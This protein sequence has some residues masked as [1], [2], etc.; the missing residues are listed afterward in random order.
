MGSRILWSATIGFLAGVL[1]R[2]FVPLGPNYALFLAAITGVF[3]LVLYLYD[4]VHFHTGVV[5]AI[6]C[7]AFAGGIM[8]M[9]AAILP[10]DPITHMYVGERVTVTG[11][12]FAEPDARETNTRLS[13]RAHTLTTAAGSSTI[14]TGILAVL[15]P[16]TH[17]TYGDEIVVSGILR[18]PESF[19]TT[20]GRVFNYPAYLAVSGISY[21]LTSAHIDSIGENSGNAGYALVI[22]IKEVYLRGLHRALAEP[23]AGLA[24]GITVGDKRSIGEDLSADFQRAS[25]IHMLVL[26]GYNITV[27]INAAAY[28]FSRFPRIIQFGTSGSIVVFF[29]ALSGGASSAVRAGLMALIA[30]YARQHGRVFLPLRA[31]GTVAVGMAL[32]NPYIVAF[33]PGFQLSAL[34]TIGL[35]AFTPIFAARMQWLTESFALREVTASTIATQ[36]TVLPLLLYQNG[37]LSLVALPANILA[38]APVPFAMFASFVA[39]IGGIFS[40]TLAA[41]IGLP[42]YLLLSYIIT[43]TRFFGSL[44]FASVSIQAFGFGWLVGAYAALFLIW[45]HTYKEKS[46]PSAALS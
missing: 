28:I 46:D 37:Q 13:I 5:I 45:K 23:Y 34:A 32:W 42:A 4:H 2:S 16:H 35:V 20:L 22:R 43:I 40:D 18:E 38:L 27:V 25:L 7:L 11:Y 10:T 19:D 6:A 17:A 39:A 33:D 30:V 14:H 36:L 29:I 12:I 3:L 26:S 31:V 21:Q 44:P 41:I 9:N 24:G 1:V 15:P 8:R